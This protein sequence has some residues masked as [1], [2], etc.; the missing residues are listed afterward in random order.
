M[1]G[2]VTGEKLDVSLVAS[3]FGRTIT[4]GTVNCGLGSIGF[5]IRLIITGGNFI[6]SIFGLSLG[7][8]GILDDNLTW[9]HLNAYRS[10]DIPLDIPLDITPDI[11]PDSPDSQLYNVSNLFPHFPTH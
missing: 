1:K 11:T 7:I 8:T 6:G 5:V 10:F 2:G 9:Y 4:V 3:G